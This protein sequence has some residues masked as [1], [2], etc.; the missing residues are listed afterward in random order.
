M[1]IFSKFSAHNTHTHTRH[2]VLYTQSAITVINIRTIHTVIYQG[3]GTEE[4]VY[5]KRK[6]SKG[7]FER[8]D[9]GRM[10]ETGS[11]FHI[12]EPVKRKST[13]HW[14]DDFLNTCVSAEERSCW[15]GM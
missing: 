10:T 13:D 6:V 4:K 14:K 2:L 11:W 3:N 7:R 1:Y 5:K 15:E 12:M 9:R 8:T